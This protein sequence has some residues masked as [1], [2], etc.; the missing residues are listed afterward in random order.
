MRS[1][2][3]LDFSFET[4]EAEAGLTSSILGAVLDKALC[5][6]AGCILD[7]GECCRCNGFGGTVEKELIEFS[8]S[9]TKTK[10]NLESWVQNSSALSNFY[11]KVCQCC[12]ET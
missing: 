1:D 3:L 9:L 12:I 6:G 2:I 10:Q 8:I 7:K 5:L 4:Q 11:K